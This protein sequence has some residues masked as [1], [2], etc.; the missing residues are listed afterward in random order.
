MKARRGDGSLLTIV[1]P[2]FNRAELIKEAVDS[3]ARQTYRPLQL[4]VVDDGSTDGTLERVL[5]WQA[6]RAS[7]GF[8]IDLIRQANLGAP[9][10]RNAG[11]K[12]AKGDYVAFLDS[13][14]LLCEEFASRMVRCLDSCDRLDLV[15]CKSRTFK[16]SSIAEKGYE[17]SA[18]Y[19]TDGSLVEVKEARRSDWRRLTWQT[20]CAVYRRSFLLEIG[21]W[22]EKLRLGWQDRELALRAQLSGVRLGVRDDVLVLIRDSGEDRISRLAKSG[23]TR[24]FR[25]V[26]MAYMRLARLAFGRLLLRDSALLGVYGLWFMLRGSGV[27]YGWLNKLRLR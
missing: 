17:I 26:A 14:D 10:A 23:D 7:E 25:G 5:D 13:D 19:T 11:L 15:V 18:P 27:P 8:E 9:A 21:G 3:V 2:V 1:I 12:A 22:S 4:I 16:G 24:F 20:A 6:K